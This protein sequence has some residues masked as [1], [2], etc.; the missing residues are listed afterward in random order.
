MCKRKGDCTGATFERMAGCSVKG[1]EYLDYK[2]DVGDRMVY[3]NI[4]AVH[5]MRSITS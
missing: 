5:L 3:S 1:G 2:E 4:R